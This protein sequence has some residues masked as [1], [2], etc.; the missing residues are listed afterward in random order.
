MIRWLSIMKS[1][2]VFSGQG[3]TKAVDLRKHLK[4]P[5][6]QSF[7][8]DISQ[9]TKFLE[10]TNSAV[11]GLLEPLSFEMIATFMNND[12]YWRK[13]KK[14]KDIQSMS[15]HSAGI[16]NLIL[17]T[18]AV[19]FSKMLEFLILRIQLL[20]KYHGDKRLYIYMSDNR[21]SLFSIAAN[22]KISFDESIVTDDNSGVLSISPQDSLTMKKLADKEHIFLKIKD[23]GIPIPYH[24]KYLNEFFNEYKKLI[25]QLF[26]GADLNRFEKYT[27]IFESNMNPK[28]EVLRQLTGTIYWNDI[29][30]YI[31]NGNFETIYDTSANG[32]VKKQIQR[33][34][35]QSSVVGGEI[36]KK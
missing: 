8:N 1:I 4:S 21:D 25:E 16:F 13:L 27:F 15:S 2:V 26:H 22:E 34:V 11:N 7:L 24:S 14:L 19:R 29:K 31:I 12:I 9:N 17:A 5:E 20:Q 3:N 18:K 10:L 23:S 30:K 35:K 33:L 28:D 6:G 32:F 36:W